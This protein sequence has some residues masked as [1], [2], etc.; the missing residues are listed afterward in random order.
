MTNFALFS[1]GGVPKIAPQMD[2]RV[3]FITAGQPHRAHLVILLVTTFLASLQ[4]GRHPRP[5]RSTDR[6]CLRPLDIIPLGLFLVI[7]FVWGSLIYFRVF[8]AVR[9]RHDIYPLV[10]QAAGCGRPGASAGGR[11]EINSLHISRGASVPV[12]ADFADCFTVFSAFL[13]ISQSSARRFQ[14]AT[15]TVCLRH[16]RRNVSPFLHAST[17]DNH[18][19]MIGDIVVLTPEDYRK[20]LMNPPAANRCAER[21]A[22]FCEPE[23]Q[24]CHNARPVCCEAPAW[25]TCNA[26]QASATPVVDTVIADDA[27][28]READPQI[29]FAARSP[30]GCMR[31]SSKRIRA[32]QRRGRD[33]SSIEFIKNLAPTT[34][35]S[36]PRTPP[37]C[38]EGEDTARSTGCRNRLARRQPKPVRQRDGEAMSTNTMFSLDRPGRRPEFQRPTSSPKRMVF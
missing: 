7:V 17:A 10:G 36:R 1:A 16:R 35:F 14:A 11:H 13:A 19:A 32:S 29:S 30:Q 24:R 25:P 31:R 3:L 22:A 28:L 20:W 34:G 21:R 26:A 38:A 18:S 12:D 5:Y 9:Q 8:T 15:T 2:A 33:C 4:Q 23:L 27:Y 37:T 6:R